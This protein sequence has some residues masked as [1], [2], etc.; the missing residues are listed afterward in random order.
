M[1]SVNEIPEKIVNFNLYNDN[2]KQIGITGEVKLPSLEAMTETISGAGIAGEYESG[3]PGHYN[4][5]EI[6]IPYRLVGSQPLALMAKK[7]STIFLRSAKQLSDISGGGI[8]HKPMKITLKVS[9][10]GLDLGKVAVGAAMETT[11]K[12]E[13]MYIKIET[14]DLV[15]LELDK[16]NFVFVVNGVD[17]LAE[18]RAMM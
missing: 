4:S 12:L 14:D 3:T 13:V 11:G 16:Q 6:E 5:M 9:P 2:E 10:K 1:A 8:V 18:I 15:I 17:Q 7:Y